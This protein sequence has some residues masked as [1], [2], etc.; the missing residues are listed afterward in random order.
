MKFE[1]KLKISSEK[2]LIVKQCIMKNIE[3]L[4]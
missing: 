2:N 4:E 1:K 3:K